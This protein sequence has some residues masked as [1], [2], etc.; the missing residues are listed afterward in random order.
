[1]TPPD[2]LQR[3]RILHVLVALS[4]PVGGYFIHT[5]NPAT[6]DPWWP[7]WVMAAVHVGL[8]AGSYVWPAVRERLGALLNIL[9]FGATAHAMSIVAIDELRPIA[10]VY[11]LVC[12][13]AVSSYLPTRTMLVGYFAYAVALA[14]AVSAL[15]WDHPFAPMLVSVLGGLSAFL[16]FLQAGRLH[17]YQQ[18]AESE[19]RFRGLFD[20]VQEALIVHDGGRILDVNP[21]FERLFRYAEADVLG[22]PLDRVVVPQSRLAFNEYLSSA[23]EDPFECIGLKESGA[24]FYLETVTRSH[25]LHGRP[26]RVSSMYDVT[27]RKRAEETIADAAH[28]D[29]LTDLPTQRL[30]LDRLSFGLATARRRREG[31]G[32]AVLVVNG[33]E[34][35]Q[36]ELGREVAEAVIVG[37]AARLKQV[38]RDSDTVARK[39]DHQFLFALTGVD[40]V[41]A[42]IAAEKIVDAF[43]DPFLIQ[44]KPVD[45]T[46]SVG[47]SLFPGH[48]EQ[49]KHLISLAEDALKAAQAGTPRSNVFVIHGLS[50]PL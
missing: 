31:I 9:L 38:T 42:H 19:A 25:Q 17:A 8:T 20:A 27:E 6:N 4:Y 32:V 11:A 16:Y 10:L 29:P 33:F 46:V 5:A 36:K 45:V 22:T 44:G 43:A 37:T 24:S 13:A 2:E 18:I 1:M 21:G 40:E 48:G 47:L 35:L 28:R 34:G 3:H 49:P 50:G 30:F 15:H 23:S 12:F 14:A 41:G 39:G 7:R 26:V